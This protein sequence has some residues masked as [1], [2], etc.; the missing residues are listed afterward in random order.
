MRAGETMADLQLIGEE[1]LNDNSSWK[2]S[3]TFQASVDINSQS[4][5]GLSLYGRRV[6]VSELRALRPPLS[7]QVN[8]LPGLEQK[9]D[10]TLVFDAQERAGMEAIIP[11]LT[12]YDIS[13]GEVV[14]DGFFIEEYSPVAQENLVDQ[15][16]LPELN[17]TP[18][19]LPQFFWPAPVS[20]DKFVRQLEYTALGL[21]I[22]RLGPAQNGAGF[23]WPDGGVVA[24]LHNDDGWSIYSAEG[25]PR[26]F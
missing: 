5:V 20:T 18:K 26:L 12:V 14:V 2:F 11:I 10:L 8:A 15:S 23:Q 9:L 4:R 13:S 3:L 25:L 16:R 17:M 7:R 6:G 19:I 1:R 21:H 24:A 22:I